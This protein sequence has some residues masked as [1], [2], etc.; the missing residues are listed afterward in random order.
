MPIRHKFQPNKLFKHRVCVLV[1]LCFI[2]VDASDNMR[3]NLSQCD[4]RLAAIIR[5][6]GREDFF[7]FGPYWHNSL[8]LMYGYQ[9]TTKA[10]TLSRKTYAD[11]LLGTKAAIAAKKLDHRALAGRNMTA[12][13]YHVISDDFHTYMQ[14]QF[15]IQTQAIEQRNT[16]ALCYI[17]WLTK[18]INISMPPELLKKIASYTAEPIQDE[19]P[20]CM[21]HAELMIMLRY[22]DT[23]SYE[24]AI[25]PSPSSTD[26]K[27]RIRV[28][29]PQEIIDLW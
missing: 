1:V 2:A 23:L 12:D 4:K 3:I 22:A 21:A 16:R 24:S 25:Y 8:N 6:E 7:I 11:F 10:I 17:I 13:E 26:T 20:Y 9:F 29:L 5:V 19:T 28:T 14:E 15:D 18:Q 27:K